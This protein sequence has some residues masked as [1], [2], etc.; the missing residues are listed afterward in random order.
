MSTDN[1]NEE[2]RKPVYW[3]DIINLQS[4]PTVTYCTDD[5]AGA[6]EFLACEA[7]DTGNAKGFWEESLG[8]E[9]L[10]HG[11][12]F[13]K[14]HGE[15]SEAFEIM[16][17]NPNRMSEKIPG[18]KAVEEEL[19]DAIILIL[20]WGHQHGYDIGAAIISKLLHNRTRPYLNGKLY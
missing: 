9:A 16:R 17:R 12:K 19:A 13:A 18:H 14:M 11:T 4:R 1:T 10:C 3:P 20:D 6:L 15:I 8:M 7:N 5:L 2:E